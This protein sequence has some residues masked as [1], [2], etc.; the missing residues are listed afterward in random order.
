[1][2]AARGDFWSAVADIITTVQ[3]QAKQG[4]GR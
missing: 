2:S 3:Q 4:V 1:M